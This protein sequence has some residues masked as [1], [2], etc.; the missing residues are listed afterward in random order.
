MKVSVQSMGLT[1]HEPLEEHIE[2]TLSKLVN[3]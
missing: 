2:K 3:Y 1:P